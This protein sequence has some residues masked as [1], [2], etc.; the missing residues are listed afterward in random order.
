MINKLFLVGLLLV[1]TA[2]GYSDC[3]KLNDFLNSQGIPRIERCCGGSAFTICEKDQMKSLH[4]NEDV[5]KNPEN[6]ISFNDFPI[7]ENLRHLTIT[8]RNEDVNLNIFSGYLPNQF[9]YQPKLEILEVTRAHVNTIPFNVNTKNKLV[10]INLNSND[11]TSFPYQLRFL[12]DLEELDVSRNQIQGRITNDIKEFK[13]LRNLNIANN[14][15]EGD[16]NIPNSLTAINS[17][18]NKFNSFA[19]SSSTFKNLVRFEGINNGF[20]DRIFNSLMKAKNLKTLTLGNNK[21]VQTIPDDIYLLNSLEN[22]DLSGTSITTLP[23]NFYALTN[24]KYLNLANLKQ[25][26][27]PIVKFGREINICN[28]E[29]TLPTC[30][31]QEACNFVLGYSPKYKECSDHE[32]QQIHDIDT[33]VFRH[34]DK[35]YNT[36]RK[37]VIFFVL[38]LAGIIIYK[39]VR[40]YIKQY[41]KK[42]KL[43][44]QYE[45]EDNDIKSKHSQDSIDIVTPDKQYYRPEDDTYLSTPV[46]DPEKEQYCTSVVSEQQFTP[47]NTDITNYN[48]DNPLYNASPVSPVQPANKTETK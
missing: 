35:K 1:N 25:L 3:D 41:L 21:A 36:L 9:F 44:E 20:D 10:K 8:A 23:K 14:L 47:Y 34:V 33:A 29:N 40:S 42:K 5:L 38:L 30:Y 32:I 12:S 19:W 16:I 37:I 11:L 22:L 45:N 4:I 46:Y 6:P 24:L 28:F 7:F 18:N 43:H 27:S 48:S 26:N 2:F 15:M 13:N 39:L 17:N 31:Q